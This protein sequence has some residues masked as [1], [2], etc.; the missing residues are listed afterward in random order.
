MRILVADDHETVRKGVCAILTT[1]QDLE[2]CE[3]ACDGREAVDK[4]K[5]LNFD[6]IILDVTMPTLSGFDAAVE[7]RKAL[8]RVPILFLS[9]HDG[10][11]ILQAAQSAGVQGYVNKTQAGK[12]LLRAVEAL[13]RGETFFPKEAHLGYEG[14]ADPIADPSA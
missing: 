1:R 6:L 12:T 3:E 13:L 11:Q 4:A 9:M 7:I 2:L 14:S 8:P 5:E 10:R